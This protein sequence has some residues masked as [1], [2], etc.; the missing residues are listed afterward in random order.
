MSTLH[1]EKLLSLLDTIN[2]LHPEERAALTMLAV[3]YAPIARSPFAL[4]LQKA[5]IR[6]D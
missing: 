5:G 3:M 2:T 4:C 1:S 6:S